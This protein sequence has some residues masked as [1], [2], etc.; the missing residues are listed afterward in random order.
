MKV[1][2]ITIGDELLIGQVIDSNAAW[3]GQKLND[4]DFE[5]QE[6][7]SVGDDADEITRALRMAFD[8]VDIVLLTGGL[9]PTKDDITKKTLATFFETE[10]VFHESTFSRIE[11]LFARWGRSL[12]PAH[13]Q[14]A[15][16][17]AN[18]T[19]LYNKMG[20]AP[21]M[22]FEQDGKV[23]VSMPG[24]PYEMKYLMGQEVIPKLQQRFPGKPLLHRTICTVGEGEARLARRLDPFL[25]RLPSNVKVAYLPRLGTVRIR[26]TARGENGTSL[27]QLLDEKVKELQSII[28]EFV[29]GF[30]DDALESVVGRLLMEKNKKLALA[31]SCTGGYTAHLIT[32]VPGASA[33][34]LG[35]IVSY[36][37]ELKTA[38]LGVPSTVLAE[39]GAVSEQTVLAM[40]EGC[41]KSTGADIAAAIS[42][43]AGPKGGTPEKPVGTIWL[44]VG[45]RQ[46]QQTLLL[47]LGKDRQRNIQYTGIQALNMIRKFL[48]DG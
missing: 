47:R 45:D 1:Q 2:I 16:M 25:E 7:T 43:I 14:Q 48:L 22:W 38:F 23:A 13:R 17:P 31:E 42:G 40:L 34:F 27:Q 24:V 29:Y 37:N 5:V 10:L 32:A 3:M 4:V 21:G 11:K 9:G 6:I 30:E 15:Y 36:A 19:I 28:P 26:L 12:T 20:T 46:Q 8:R 39:H 35:S 41:L 44:A 33:Y 18:A